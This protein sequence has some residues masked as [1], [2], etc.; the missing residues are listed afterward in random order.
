MKKLSTT[1]CSESNSLPHYRADAGRPGDRC[2][3]LSSRFIIQTPTA[4]DGRAVL[5]VQGLKDEPVQLMNWFHELLLT[6]NQFAVSSDLVSPVLWDFENRKNA[7]Y[8]ADI[9]W[10]RRHL[11]VWSRINQVSLPTVY[12]TGSLLQASSWPKSPPFLG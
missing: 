2:G 8:G 6:V 12:R 4:S 11:R 9:C 1:T 10:L 7:I 3:Q 5:P